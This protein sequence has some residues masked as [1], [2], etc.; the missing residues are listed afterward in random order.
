MVDFECRVIDS[1]NNGVCLLF[2]VL[3][4]PLDLRDRRDLIAGL[5]VGLLRA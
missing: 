2:A 5:G 1:L 3:G 4:F